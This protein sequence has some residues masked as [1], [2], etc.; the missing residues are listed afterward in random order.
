MQLERSFHDQF[1]RGEMKVSLTDL[2]DIQK[3]NGETIDDYLA[4]FKN[5]KNKCYTPVPEAKVVKMALNGL[6]YSIWKK[7][8]NQ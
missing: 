3:F 5:L 4:R 8:V 6:G 7:L 2:F 1:F